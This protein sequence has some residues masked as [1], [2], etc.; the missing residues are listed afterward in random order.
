MTCRTTLH[1]CGNL[2]YLQTACIGTPRRPAMENSQ[3]ALKLVLDALDEDITIGSVKDR[4]RL[5]KAVYLSQI[6]GVPLGYSYS[7][8]VKGPYSPDLTQDYYALNSAIRAGQDIDG[9]VL[10]S[11]LQPQ[12]ALTKQILRLPVGVDEGRK[13]EWYET[14]A[15]LHFLVKSSRMSLTN[16]RTFL[17]QVKPH[18]ENLIDV[19]QNR[20]CEVFPDFDQQAR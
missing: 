9:K 11:S 15:S 18:T 5:Q 2:V 1:I 12:V 14:L 19:A 4:M 20:L 13:P 16:A 7:W 3:L 8:Y 17:R 10:N 6:A